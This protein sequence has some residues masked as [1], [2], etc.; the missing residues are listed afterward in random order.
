MAIGDDYLTREELKLYMGLETTEN[1]DL[2]D[3]AISSASREI[4]RHCHRQFNDAGAASARLY[5]AT[6]CHTVITDD[7]HT[8]VGLLVEI[9]ESGDGTTWTTVD[10]SQYELLPLNRMM[11]GLPWV[12]WRI[13]MVDATSFPVGRRAGVRVTAQWGWESVPAD[14]KQACKMLGSDTYQL[15]DSRMGVA[16]SDQFG[17]IVRVKDNSLVGAKL[18]NFVRSKVLV[19]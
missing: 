8:E 13:K 11:H 4:E 18:K 16:G 19:K 7:F 3:D 15:K 17:T 6:N 9:N 1:D 14:I 10:S 2:V 12:Y 5:H